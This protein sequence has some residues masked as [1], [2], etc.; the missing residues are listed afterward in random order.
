VTSPE[1]WLIRPATAA[2]VPAITAIQNAL[3]STTTIE[4]RDDLHT[5][6]ER[7]AWLER[8]EAE[9]FPVLVAEVDGAIVGFAAYGD[10]RDTA[11]WPGYRYVVEHTVHVREDQWGSGVGRAL[12]GALLEHA[13]AAGRHVMVG[14][15]DG[16][17]EAS[18]RFHERLGFTEVARL[19]Q[20]GA[21]H[22]RWLDLVLLQV[23]LDERSRP[24]D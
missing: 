20:V 5:D 19:P 23:V 3:I 16:A 18:I 17:N 21:K 2:D 1:S 9:G 15:V 6:S 8:C 10:F 7:G 14:A 24:P 22:G 4:W 13:R 11:K 12:M